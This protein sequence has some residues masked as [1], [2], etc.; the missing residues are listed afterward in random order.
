MVREQHC[1][2]V[3]SC[4]NGGLQGT[5]LMKL[6]LA[7]LYHVEKQ[8][9]EYLFSKIACKETENSSEPVGLQ[10]S[11]VCYMA[12][13]VQT[14]KHNFSLDVLAMRSSTQLSFSSK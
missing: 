7:I 11:C 12:S 9:R 2:G 13:L 3:T 5:K 1:C 4:Y 14:L 10:L 6:E 8:L